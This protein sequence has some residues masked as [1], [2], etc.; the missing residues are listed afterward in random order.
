MMK[1]KIILACMVLVALICLGMFGLV[2]NYQ[3]QQKVAAEENLKI[4]FKKSASD[5]NPSFALAITTQ[6]LD[7]ISAKLK[8]ES[9]GKFVNSSVEVQPLFITENSIE[10]DPVAVGEKTTFRQ[11]KQFEVSSPNEWADIEAVF[12]SDKS[13]NAVM[14]KI[15][16]LNSPTSEN[17]TVIVPLTNSPSFSGVKLPN[18]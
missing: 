11:S 5:S 8:F 16:A 12:P 10:K 4:E 13:V 14:L 17:I 6:R 18:L 3:W 7:D 1:K 9:T 2:S 15:S